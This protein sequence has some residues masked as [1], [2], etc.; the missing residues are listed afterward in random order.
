MTGV[1]MSHGAI[2]VLNAIPN[3]IG[4][5][6]GIDL[7]TKAVFEPSDERRI[8]LIGRPGMDA[9][10]AETCVMRTLERIGGDPGMGF[11]LEVESEIPP[12]RGLKSSSSVCDAV[13]LSVLDHFKADM[14]DLEII[15]LGVECAKECGVTITGA[16]DDACGC[17]FGGLVITDNTRCELLSRREMPDHDVILCIPDE[18]IPKS[19]VD[20]SAYRRRRE[21]YDSL[22]S[23]IEEDP[24]RVLTENGRIVSEII[25]IEDTVSTKAM[26]LGALASGITGT[27]PA[28]AIVAENGRGMGIAEAI[29]GRT[30]LSRIA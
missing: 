11:R 30:I 19:G 29:G 24:M 26:S 15:R 22:S 21:E 6:I 17:H 1:G 25:G 5:T 4:S 8:E 14:D 20:V 18:E 27:G 2:S 9:S 7:R 10:L 16:F 3:G 13:I 28:V 12:S 23:M